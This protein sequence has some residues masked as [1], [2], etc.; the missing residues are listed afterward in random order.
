MG[1]M[2][3]T[4]IIALLSCVGGLLIGIAWTRQRT[5]QE[6]TQAF[7]DGKAE[8]ESEKI[9]VSLELSG[10]L[11][12]IRESLEQ[13]MAAYENAMELVTDRLVSPTVPA[14]RRIPSQ[15]SKPLQLEFSHREETPDSAH[16]TKPGHASDS[17]VRMDLVEDEDGEIPTVQSPS[18]KSQLEQEHLSVTPE[19]SP[20]SVNE[21][22]Q[23]APLQRPQ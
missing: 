6:I 16:P 1:L 9:E 21:T 22:P 4:I 11:T 10:Q 12:A 5:Q 14:H 15:I 19:D 13:S 17:E 18:L 7:E 23:E 3:Y 20:L 8:V 2:T